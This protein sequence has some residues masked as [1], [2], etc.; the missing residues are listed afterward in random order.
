MIVTGLI[1]FHGRNSFASVPGFLNHKA[2]IHKN[3]PHD[4]TVQFVIIRKE[5][6]L[7]LQRFHVLCLFRSRLIIQRFT[8]GIGNG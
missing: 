2:V 5:D 8:K 1:P 4:L 6:S 7:P 3:F